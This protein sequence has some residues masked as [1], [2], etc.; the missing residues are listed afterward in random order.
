MQVGIGSVLSVRPGLRASTIFVEYG[1]N[2]GTDISRYSEQELDTVAN[3][4]LNLWLGIAPA[5]NSLNSNVHCDP[6]MRTPHHKY[7]PARIYRRA[8]F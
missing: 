6:L 8:D 5:L 3:A 1:K 2:K 4:Q 7:V